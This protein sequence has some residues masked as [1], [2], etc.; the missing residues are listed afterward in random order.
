[1]LTGVGDDP[2]HDDAGRGHGDGSAGSDDG[3]LALADS[4]TSTS[5]GELPEPRRRRAMECYRQLRP[6]LEQGV[7]LARVSPTSPNR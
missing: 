3:Q 6:H 1:V 7:P 2:G 5:L 4:A